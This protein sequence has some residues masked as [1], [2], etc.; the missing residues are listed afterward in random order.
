MPAEFQFCDHTSYTLPNLQKIGSSNMYSTECKEC[1]EQ[2]AQEAAQ[3]III[4]YVPKMTRLEAIITE[5]KYLRDTTNLAK[6]PALER[7]L[8]ELSEAVDEKRDL[9]KEEQGKI[10]N[11]WKRHRQLYPDFRL[12]L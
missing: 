4:A 9:E 11:A 12:G 1:S 2:E 10:E 6:S 8:K 5:R 3:A 7:V